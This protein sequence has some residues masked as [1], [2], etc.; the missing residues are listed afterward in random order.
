M[1]WETD[2]EEKL[3]IQWEEAGGPEIAGIPSKK[4]FGTTPVEKT[5]V[6]Q[7]AGTINYDWKSSGVKVNLCIALGKLGAKRVE[8]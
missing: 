5:A 7:F 4:G 2:E 3:G 1:T 6:S 8:S